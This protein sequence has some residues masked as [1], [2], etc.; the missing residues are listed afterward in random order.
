M[1]QRVGGVPCVAPPEHDDPGYV[2]ITP[3]LTVMTRLP[4]GFNDDG[5]PEYAWF[6]VVTGEATVWEERTEREDEAAITRIVARVVILYFGP[7]VGEEVSVIA[8]WGRYRARKVDQFPDRL[9]MTVVR[10]EDG[11]G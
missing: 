1:K 5:D 6:D 7:P 4:D 2:N 11:D 10:L 8:E 3:V 9:E